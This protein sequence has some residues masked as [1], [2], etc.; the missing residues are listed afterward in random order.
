MEA[1]SIG[2]WLIG[3]IIFSLYFVPVALAFVRKAKPFAGIAIVNV[4]LGW[5]I[6]GWI[7]ALVWASVA[8]P[9]HA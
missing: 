8:E 9:R 3:W 6:L 1:L 5:T 7:G 2:H 4:L